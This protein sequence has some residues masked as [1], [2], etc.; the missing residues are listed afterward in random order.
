[1]SA[2]LSNRWW[3]GVPGPSL[4]R[5]EEMADSVRQANHLL[6]PSNKGLMQQQEGVRLTDLY[7]H[8]ELEPPKIR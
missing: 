6:R 4:S 2:W 5:L 7:G 8:R 1:M 3:Y